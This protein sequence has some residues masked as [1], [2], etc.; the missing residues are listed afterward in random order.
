MT[1]IV[2][3]FISC[4]IM[5]TIHVYTWQKIFEIKL[6]FKSIKTIFLLLLM[7]FAILINYMYIINYLKIVS[8]TLVLMIFCKFLFNV[9]A[10]KAIIAPIVSQLFVAF[11]EFVFALIFLNIIN[12]ND[13]VVFN[14]YVGTLL[15]NIVVAL[16]V[17]VL[18]KIGLSKKAYLLFEKITYG[19]EKYNLLLFTLILIITINLIQINIYYNV[20]IRTLIVV[21][22][23]LMI[24]YAII[25]FKMANTQNKYLIISNRYNNSK[26][27]LSEYQAI[28]NRYRID[29]HENKNQLRR[30]KGKID[31]NNEEALN[32]IDNILNTRIKPNEKILN[33]TKIIPECDLRTLIDAKIMT[34][35]EKQIKN[36][37]H[38]DKQIKTTDFIEMDNNLV[39]DICKIVGV[40]LD[41]AIEAVENLNKKEVQLDLYNIDGYMHISVVN[42]YEGH[43]DLDKLNNVGYTTK[44]NG[45]GY[46]LALV[47]EIV[48]NNKVLSKETYI[49]QHIFKQVLK[50]KM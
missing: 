44:S 38:V 35:E 37:I 49:D 28:I 22:I 46:G 42:N 14:N 7:P 5:E 45:H 8:I 6:E 32:Y 25:I 20:S 21:N 1:D 24:T 29:N 36:T 23:V 40:Y 43:I 13:Y 31:P 47:N 19:I 9:S 27:S 17:F 18:T 4:V 41:N 39:E 3:K 11:S 10:K 34:M 26:N 50:I 30:L 16:I 2:L 48:E 15:P 33:K 12:L